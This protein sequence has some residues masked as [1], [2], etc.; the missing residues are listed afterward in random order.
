MLV[1][2]LRNTTPKWISRK[3]G[4]KTSPLSYKVEIDGVIHRRHVD[5]MIPSIV[6]VVIS[7]MNA[8][9]SQHMLTILQLLNQHQS[10]LHSHIVT[11]QEIGISLFC[12]YFLLFFF[13][14]IFFSLPIICS[15]FCSSPTNLFQSLAI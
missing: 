10:R 15:T 12:F 8:E 7:D 9:E 3:I 6:Q 4:A 1:E 11:L 14:Q 13:P 2:N 5:Q